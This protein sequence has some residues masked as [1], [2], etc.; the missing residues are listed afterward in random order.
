MNR[1]SHVVMYPYKKPWFRQGRYLGGTRI[2]HFC[3]G[4]ITADYF[5]NVGLP[6][7]A[8]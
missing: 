1:V 6:M 7:A 8:G 3:V 5:L 4:A 2:T